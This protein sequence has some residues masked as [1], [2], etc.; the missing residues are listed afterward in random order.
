M[1][2]TE[3]HKKFGTQAKCIS[4]LEKLRWNKKPY[5]VHCGSDRVTKRK[6][7]I[8]WH[9]N[10]CNKDGSVLIGTIFEECRFPLPKFF[11]V[12]VLLI[13][14]PMGTSSKSIQ[15][16]VGLSYKTAWYAAH[17]IRC[18][19]IEKEIRLEGIIE[20]DEAYMGSKKKGVKLA[21]NVPSLGGNQITLKRGRGTKKIPV[22]GAVE[23]KGSVSVKIVEKLTGRNLLAMLKKIVNTK[24]SVVVTDSFKSYNAFDETVEHIKI[25]HS[26]GF[27]HGVKT[28]NTIE[29]FW[30]ILKNGIKGNYRAISKKYLP[31]YLAEYSYRYNTR[32]IQKIGFEKILINSVKDEKCMTNYKP[33]CSPKT[34]A[35]KSK[36]CKN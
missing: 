23:K 16:N 17:R 22:V 31:F 24:D 30:S 3:L 14:S 26:E 27:G 13:N 4:Y 32:N 34:I 11:E 2:L 6:N 18:A 5:C 19:M 36:G 15:R 35:Y 12:I 21:E 7:S 20:F 9:C 25:K 28:I 33:I 10:A 8:K 1:N 29:G